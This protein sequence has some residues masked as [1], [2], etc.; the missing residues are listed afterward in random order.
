MYE[1]KCGSCHPLSTITAASYKE[2]EWKPVVERM[3]N[4][5][6]SMSDSEAEQITKYLSENVN[7]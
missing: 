5:P 2:D 4:M 7:N 3:K 6:G 1:S